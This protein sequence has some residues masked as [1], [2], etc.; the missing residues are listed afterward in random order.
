MKCCGLT[1]STPLEVPNLDFE[2]IRV[3]ETATAM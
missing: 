1:E 2:S 3:V